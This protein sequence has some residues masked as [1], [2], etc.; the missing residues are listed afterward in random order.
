MSLPPIPQNGILFL[1]SFSRVKVS[2]S[3]RLIN[4]IVGKSVQT[5]SVLSAQS[6]CVCS[7]TSVAISVTQPEYLILGNL[8][9]AACMWGM[10]G[11][12]RGRQA[13]SRPHSAAVCLLQSAGECNLSPNPFA[14]SQLFSFV[15]SVFLIHLEWA[16]RSTW[17][18]HREEDPSHPHSID[19]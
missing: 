6:G 7:L 9:G 11:K 4:G 15:L 3:K 19:F 2:K 14:C 13:G 17:M 8:Y 1:P 12:Q 16:A 5:H 18:G 10:A